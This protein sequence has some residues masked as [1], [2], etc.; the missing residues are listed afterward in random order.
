MGGAGTSPCQPCSG[1]SGCSG[2]A[3]LQGLPS[4]DSHTGMSCCPCSGCAEAGSF[5]DPS[6]TPPRGSLGAGVVPQLW[7]CQS[8]VGC[9]PTPCLHPDPTSS[10]PRHS[11]IRNSSQGQSP[12]PAPTPW[13]GAD[14]PAWN[15]PSTGCSQVTPASS[16]VTPRPGTPSLHTQVWGH[17]VLGTLLSHCWY[18][19]ATGA[20]QCPC[21]VARVGWVVL[22]RYLGDDGF[23]W[24]VLEDWGVV[25]TVIH[26]DCELSG[27]LPGIREGTG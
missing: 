14:V 24:Q 9:S 26:N 3:G 25:I 16:A 6:P 2:P 20:T 21:P 5:P 15:W 7:G 11:L 13:T 22:G 23:I 27:D 1:C 19:H 10:Q 17:P 4:A 18:T 8:R 12:V